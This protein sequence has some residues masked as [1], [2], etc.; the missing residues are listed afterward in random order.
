MHQHEHVGVRV[1]PG[2]SRLPARRT[3]NSCLA[4]LYTTHGSRC[5]PL[6]GSKPPSIGSVD[7]HAT[8]GF[9]GL[10]SW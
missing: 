4:S 7:S 1:D 3:S 2:G 9:F 10:A 5:G 8:T 6:W